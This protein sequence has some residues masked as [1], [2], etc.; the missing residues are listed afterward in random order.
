M[1]GIFRPDSYENETA[2]CGKN[3]YISPYIGI[4]S[5][6]PL[7]MGIVLPAGTFEAEI[8]PSI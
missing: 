3:G 1:R 5:M 4:I 6:L 8:S 7:Y 2:E